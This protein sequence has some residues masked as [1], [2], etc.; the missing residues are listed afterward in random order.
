MVCGLDHSGSQPFKYR[1]VSSVYRLI[2]L[3]MCVSVFLGVCIICAFVRTV[4]ALV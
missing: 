1:I 3:C 4:H 2:I